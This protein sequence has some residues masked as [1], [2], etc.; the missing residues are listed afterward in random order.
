MLVNYTKS[1]KVLV[2]HL[3]GLFEFHDE[4]KLM[5]AM[6]EKLDDNLSVIGVDLMHVEN[7]NSAA[8]AALLSMLKM[9]DEKRID[10]VIFAMNQKIQILLEKVFAR[11]YVPL[12]TEEE[13]RSR[14][15]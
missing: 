1:G 10:F 14:Y 12:L 9:A 13:F 6:R 15:L 5:S 3:S 11:N 2:F 8:M 7:L 4:A